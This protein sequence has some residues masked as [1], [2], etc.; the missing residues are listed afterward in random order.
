[1]KLGHLDQAKKTYEAI[2]L[3]QPNIAEVHK[4]LGLIYYKIKENPGKVTYH[5]QESLRFSP[6]QSDATQ[7]KSMI[8]LLAHKKDL[9]TPLFFMR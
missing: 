1:M 9:W 6:N 3:K 7:I 2:L 8:Q 4:N 5:F